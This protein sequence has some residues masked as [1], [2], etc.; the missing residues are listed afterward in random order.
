M[1]PTA[2]TVLPPTPLTPLAWCSSRAAHCI[3]ATSPSWSLWATSALQRA[4]SSGVPWLLRV[5]C[6]TPIPAPTTERWSFP[7][8]T[9]RKS[10]WS[11]R[12]PPILSNSLRRQRMPAS[13]LAYC[14]SPS[15]RSSLQIRA[16]PVSLFWTISPLRSRKLPP[17]SSAGWIPQKT[18]RICA[19]CPAICR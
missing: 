3:T 8:S 11:T 18:M 19:S 13:R 10:A 6:S 15:R 16:V 5:V 12:L 4:L 1:R 2:F 17:N 14:P 9:S 7:S